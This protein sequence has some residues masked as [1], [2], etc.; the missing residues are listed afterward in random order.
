MSCGG[1]QANKKKS[2]SVARSAL[3]A[4]IG[5]YCCSSMKTSDNEDKRIA[6]R[7]HRTAR[8][9]IAYAYNPHEVGGE[10]GPCRD[11]NAVMRTVCVAVLVKLY[12]SV[13]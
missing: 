6:G 5:Y 1:C 9:R 2:P 3:K 13:L 4:S 11:S 7:N 10:P 12:S 8:D